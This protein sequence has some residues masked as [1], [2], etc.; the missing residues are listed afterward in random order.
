MSCE[1][2]FVNLRKSAEEELFNIIENSLYLHNR[3]DVLFVYVYVTNIERNISDDVVHRFGH[4]SMMS[5]IFKSFDPATADILVRVSGSF[6][7]YLDHMKFESIQA[8][9]TI[10]YCHATQQIEFPI[11]MGAIRDTK[12][13]M[14]M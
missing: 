4:N 5:R 2:Y 14:S 11:D 6:N 9:K 1:D 10:A 3:N 13:L 7:H 8:P 12:I